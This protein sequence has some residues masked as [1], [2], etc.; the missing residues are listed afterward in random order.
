MSELI[1][2]SDIIKEED[3]YL[4]KSRAIDS[5]QEDSKDN[6][7]NQKPSDYFQKS[8]PYSGFGIKSQQN[9]TEKIEI[10]EEVLATSIKRT[11]NEQN[12][13][14]S[15]KQM[16]NDNSYYKPSNSMR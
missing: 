13:T 2:Q 10:N 16:L 8:S 4:K 15:Q 3:E 7:E 9:N 5:D 6:E 11:E 12:P 14:N 1:N